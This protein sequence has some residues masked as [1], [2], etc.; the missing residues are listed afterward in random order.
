VT[1]DPRRA[2]VP[3]PIRHPPGGG[4][5]AADPWGRPVAGVTV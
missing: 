4:R 2:R 5:L 1:G 3:A